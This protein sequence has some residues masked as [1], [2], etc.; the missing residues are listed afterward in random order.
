MSGSLK[1]QRKIRLN[2]SA[3]CR[4]RFEWDINKHFFVLLLKGRDRYE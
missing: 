4:C 2:V 1:Y 3:F